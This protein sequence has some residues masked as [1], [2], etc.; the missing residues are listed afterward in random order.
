MQSGTEIDYRL[1]Y[2]VSDTVSNIVSLFFGLIIVGITVFLSLVTTC[3]LLYINYPVIRGRV[4]E[5]FDGTHFGGLRLVS[6]DAR[7]ALTEAYTTGKNPLEV[8][9]R[10]RVKTYLI[11]ACTLF[12]LI[13]GGESLRGLATDIVIKALSAFGFI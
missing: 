11:S 5:S 6:K 13:T 2:S 9:L 10:K 1:L 4:D 12:I 8:Y 3:D 7:S